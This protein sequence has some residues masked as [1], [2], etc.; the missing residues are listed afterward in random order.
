MPSCGRSKTVELFFLHGVGT[1]H[2]HGPRSVIRQCK[3]VLDR[4]SGDFG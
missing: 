1:L 3:K 2:P 4:F